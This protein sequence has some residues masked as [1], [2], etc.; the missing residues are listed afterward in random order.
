MV[1][2]QLK[3]FSSVLIFVKSWMPHA[4][5]SLCEEF[6]SNKRP[7]PHSARIC[8]DSGRAVAMCENRS[9]LNATPGGG[10][11]RGCAGPLGC[12]LLSDAEPRDRTERNVSRGQMTS[13]KA[14]LALRRF[15][16]PGL[17]RQW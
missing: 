11:T 16:T 3:G 17:R 6:A 15:L 13:I 12:D 5:I 1:T 14:R 10:C 4:V 7:L 2:N 9:M 8:K